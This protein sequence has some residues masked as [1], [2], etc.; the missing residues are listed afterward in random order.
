MY[1]WPGMMI[2]VVASPQF[3]HAVLQ[4]GG[5]GNLGTSWCQWR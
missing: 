3:S 1:E 5:I 2:N 4:P